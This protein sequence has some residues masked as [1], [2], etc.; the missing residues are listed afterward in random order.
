MDLQTTI[1]AISTAPGMG[2]I[3]VIRISGPDAFVIVSKL[4]F[5]KQKPFNLDTAL[6]YSLHYGSLIQDDH[7]IDDVVL[8]LF[9]GPK[10]YTGEDTV[11][12]SC[13]GSVY[14]Q[15]RI[16]EALMAAGAQAA[17]PGEFSMR[18]FANGKMDLSQAEAVAD[19]IFSESAAAHKLAI[20]QMRGGFSKRLTELREQ[21]INFAA[22]LELELDF[23][24]EDVEFANRTELLQLLETIHAEVQR[25]AD[26]FAIGN[27]LKN[28]IP[29]TI[30]GPPNAGKSTLLNALLQEDKAIVSDIAGTTRDAIEDQMTIEGVRFRFIDTAGIRDTSDVVE[31]IGIQRTYEK[32]KQATIVIL[33]FDHAG[34]SEVPKEFQNIMAQFPE[35]HYILTANK[36]DQTNKPL[37]DTPNA[38][39]SCIGISA[40]SQ[41]GIDQLTK[42]LLHASGTSQ[43]QQADIIVTNVRHQS[44]LR[45]AGT[46]L[47]AARDGLTTGLSSDLVA[48][49]LR[50][51]LKALGEITGH[52][53]IDR[54][55][56]G[57]IFGKFCIGK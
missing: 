47:M 28:G 6:P 18:A 38:A 48:F 52:I 8:S 11:E 7:L 21:L 36:I 56:L 50:D 44:A 13:H 51:A 34:S 42:A 37:P 17:G 19:L 31:S 23:G 55:I 4:F 16:M 12:I 41:S 29:V 27:A 49:H 15:Q 1:C 30:A 46:A 54:D 53:D 2:A 20:N 9:K 57:T 5:K 39:V 45:Q 33:L 40:K 3:A 25:L 43:W 10:S 26:S 32:I 35:K 14:I 24:E 22:L